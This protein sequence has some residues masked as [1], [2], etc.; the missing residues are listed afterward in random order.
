MHKRVTL[1]LTPDDDK[2]NRWVLAVGTFE[3]L[4]A[5]SRLPSQKAAPVCIFTPNLSLNKFMGIVK[6]LH[7]HSN[8]QTGFSIWLQREQSLSPE[9]KV[10]SVKA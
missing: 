3:N 4:I 5:T 10:H 1:V 6:Y 2:R 9:T 8:T 7:T